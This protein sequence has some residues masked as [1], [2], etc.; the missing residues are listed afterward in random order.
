MIDVFYDWA[1]SLVRGQIECVWIV[2][3][4]PVTSKEAHTSVFVSWLPVSASKLHLVRVDNHDGTLLL[5]VVSKHTA[6]ALVAHYH[7]SVALLRIFVDFKVFFTLDVN[8]TV[9]NHDME[10]WSLLGEHLALGAIGKH[11]FQ[12]ETAVSA[13]ALSD[14]AF[15][16]LC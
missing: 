11:P 9:T 3:L 10:G 6:F 14:H 2:L 13:A 7:V 5:G 16:T 12:S 4:V 15:F 1:S 8:K